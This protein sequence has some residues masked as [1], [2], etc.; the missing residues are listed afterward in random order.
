MNRNFVKS[1][2]NLGLKA[3]QAGLASLEYAVC[4]APLEPT[5]SPGCKACVAPV[6]LPAMRAPGATPAVAALLAKMVRMD[7]G[8]VEAFPAGL[9]R[10]VFRGD[11]AFLE[12]M[13]SLAC[14]ASLEL[15]EVGR[16]VIC[17][18]ILRHSPFFCSCGSSWK[19]RQTRTKGA[20]R[21]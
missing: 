3:L 8:V 16:T 13:G 11:P 12:R 1:V 9:A 4:P 10:W 20:Q 19:K 17:L 6:V 21:C 7:T 2:K 15:P 14:A 5:V 18:L